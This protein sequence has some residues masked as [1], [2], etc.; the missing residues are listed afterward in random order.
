M[1]QVVPE[2]LELVKNHQVLTAAAEFPTFIEDFLDVRFTARCGNDLAGN[3]AEPFKAFTAHAFR[4]NRDRFTAQQIRVIGAAAAIITS[5]GPDCFLARGVELTGYQ[6]G[7][8][9]AERCANLVAASWEP[10]ANQR[11]HPRGYASKFRRKLNIVHTAKKAAAR[12][13]FVM[14]GNP[15]QV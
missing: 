13:R 8:Q 9:A 6:A 5:G 10:F 14:P 12:E 3:F 2:F 15:E 4:Q 1:P 7:N 11:N